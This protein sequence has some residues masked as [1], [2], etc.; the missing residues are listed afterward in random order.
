MREKRRAIVC[1]CLDVTLEEIQ[2]AV[3]NGY[4]EIETLKRYTGALTGM[5]Q[6]KYCLVNLLTVLGTKTDKVSHGM[7]LPTV[8]QPAY[9]VPLGLISVAEEEA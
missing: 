7:R 4:Q 6:G 5:C 1:S 9:D 2:E 8:R 3:D